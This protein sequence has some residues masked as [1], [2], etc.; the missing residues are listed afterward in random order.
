MNRTEASDLATRISQTWPRG[1]GANVWED[2]LVDL[3]VGRAG[4]AFVKLRRTARSAPSIAEFF[5]MYSSLHTE[6]RSTRP[7]DCPRCDNQG[8]VATMIRTDSGAEVWGPVSACSCEWG[9]RK[10]DAL[11]K[12]AAWNVRE[13][14]RI[15][16]ARHDTPSA[17]PVSA[18]EPIS[19]F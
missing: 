16:P 8:T 9:R 6:D 12:A 1:I 7:D 19:M 11:A 15:F 4:T 3:E 5:E 10:A 13:L 2:E 18:A 17:P 14:D